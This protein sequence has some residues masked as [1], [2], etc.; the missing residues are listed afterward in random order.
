MKL[1]HIDIDK[2][3]RSF[4]FVMMYSPI[5][6]VNSKFPNPRANPFRIKIKSGREERE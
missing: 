2:K 1:F 3:Y 4:K 5:F 6:H